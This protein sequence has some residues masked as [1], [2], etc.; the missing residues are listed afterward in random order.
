MG[1]ETKPQLQRLYGTAFPTSEELRAHLHQLEEAKKRDHRVLGREL[2]L[3]AIDD[4][5][6]QGL[7]LWK[8][9]GA[10]IRQELQ[11]FISRATAQAGLPAGLHPAHRPA[12]ALQ[13]QRALPV[14]P[15]RA[16]SRRWSSAR[17]GSS[18]LARS[19]SCAE[20]IEPA[21]EGRRRRLPAQADELPAPHQD[22]R[23]ATAE[24]PRPAGA[25]GGVRH[26]LPLGADPASSAA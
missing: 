5:V 22:L 17:T 21:G 2:G 4:E 3:F 13:D 18:S 6:G 1:D 16:S 10:I 12:R 26:R 9:K 14:L 20:L 24:L 7:V 25:P 19:C 15:A 11:N 8:P 23:A